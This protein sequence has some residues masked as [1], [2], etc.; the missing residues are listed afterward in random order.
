MAADRDGDPQGTALGP[1]HTLFQTGPLRPDRR[2]GPDG[3]YYAGAYTTP[4][5][6]MPMCLVS[7]ERTARAVVEDAPVRAPSRPVVSRHP[8]AKRRSSVSPPGREEVSVSTTAA[9][10]SPYAE[11]GDAVRWSSR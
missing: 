6:G 1:A 10:V 5:I 2:A 7:G 9:V 3:L 8:A 4:G 11:P